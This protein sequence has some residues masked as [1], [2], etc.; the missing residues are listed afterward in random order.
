MT[1]RNGATGELIRVDVNTTSGIPTA[2][3]GFCTNAATLYNAP[4]MR[5]TE[6]STQPPTPEP[7]SSTPRSATTNRRDRRRFLGAEPPSG[8]PR[9]ASPAHGSSDNGAFCSHGRFMGPTFVSHRNSVPTPRV[10]E[11]HCGFAARPASP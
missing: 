3:A 6:T 11:R 7:D 8:S 1:M 4:T 2:V 10:S 5:A 9:T